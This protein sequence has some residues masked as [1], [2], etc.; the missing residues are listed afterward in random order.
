MLDRFCVQQAADKG[1]AG[2]P[3]EGRA[4]LASEH[5]RWV[6]RLAAQLAPPPLARRAASGVRACRARSHPS[7]LYP[8]DRLHCELV[9]RVALENG[10]PI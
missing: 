10:I 1:V 9:T 4:G 3:R 7:L 6:A 5:Q 2:R 8:I